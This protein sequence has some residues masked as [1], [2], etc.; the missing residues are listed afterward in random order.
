MKKTTS[1]CLVL[2]MLMTLVCLSISN[3]L[4]DTAQ[5]RIKTGKNPVLRSTPSVTGETLG[6]AESDHTYEILDISGNWYKICLEDGTEGWVGKGMVT[7]IG[8][9]SSFTTPEPK[10][11]S[12]AKPSSSGNS[13]NQWK[14]E[15]YKTLNYNE[16]RR[17]PMENWFV[18]YIITGTIVQIFRVQKTFQADNDPVSQYL[19]F[20]IATK[21][22]SQNIVVCRIDN[23]VE[24]AL[25]LSEFI[26]GDKVKIYCTCQGSTH[27]DTVGGGS[28]SYPIF[29]VYESSDIILTQMAQ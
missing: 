11:A 26:E 13:G 7:V 2:M 22:S 15:T 29:N 1:I 23:S 3:A 9:T 6:Y 17:H 19:C 20:A 25:V 4:S 28:V 18:K 16:V 5:I 27:F 8:D 21:G 24:N 14:G 12:T 10:T